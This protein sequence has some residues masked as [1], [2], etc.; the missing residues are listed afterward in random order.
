MAVSSVPHLAVSTIA[1]AETNALKAIRWSQIDVHVPRA[2]PV[3]KNYSHAS[4]RVSFA[5]MG[6]RNRIRWVNTHFHSASA[7]AV[8][9]IRQPRSFS[10]FLKQFPLL[11]SLTASMPQYSPQV[12]ATCYEFGRFV[13]KGIEQ[14]GTER[15]CIDISMYS[16]DVGCICN[17][18]RRFTQCVVCENGIENPDHIIEEVG[19]TCRDN[20]ELIRQDTISYG[21]EETCNAIKVN[22]TV[23]GCRCIDLQEEE[24]EKE[25]G[26]DRLTECIVCENGFTN[27]DFVITE[28]SST[29]GVA[30]DFIRE[31]IAIYG[32][33]SMCDGTKEGIREYGCVCNDDVVKEEESSGG[34]VDECILCENGFKNP[35]F[36]IAEIKARCSDAASFIRGN[37][38]DYGTAIACEQA[39]FGTLGYGCECNNSNDLDDLGLEVV[40]YIDECTICE[41]GFANEIFFLDKYQASCND[42]AK[43]VSSNI[44]DYGTITACNA[45]RIELIEAGCTC[46]KNEDEQTFGKSTNSFGV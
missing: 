42:V 30:A 45:T 29:C 18:G 8:A 39:R 16:E 44:E 26:T 13:R 37:I 38:Q 41:N 11:L 23:S 7:K 33:A 22:A 19:V 15:S 21:T 3:A 28:Q 10:F 9:R 12:K 40:Q 4:H 2:K 25:T 43:V 27:P 14:F 6:F 36:F 1:I 34:L 5:R 20:A 31:N 32:E 24:T 17:G 46:N 35:D